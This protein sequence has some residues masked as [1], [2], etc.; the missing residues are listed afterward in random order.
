MKGNQGLWMSVSS[1][2]RLSFGE[3]SGSL[4]AKCPRT[5]LSGLNMMV[6]LI[7]KKRKKEQTFSLMK[8]IEYIP[9]AD[10]NVTSFDIY[11]I[12]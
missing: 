7:E 9:V 3:G 1:K 12:D 8:K 6:I 4:V 11:L 2:V 5:H 10:K